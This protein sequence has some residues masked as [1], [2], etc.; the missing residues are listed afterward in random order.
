MQWRR[1]TLDLAELATKRYIEGW[2]LPDLCMHFGRGEN[3][4]QWAYLMLKRQGFRHKQITE[5]LRKKL[6]KAAAVT[7]KGKKCLNS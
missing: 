1:E 6:V 7:G 3:T 4:V 2:K 5:D